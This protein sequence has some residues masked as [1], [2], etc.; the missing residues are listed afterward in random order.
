MKAKVFALSKGKDCV[1][2]TSNNKR[3]LAFYQAAVPE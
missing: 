2:F 1:S 3:K